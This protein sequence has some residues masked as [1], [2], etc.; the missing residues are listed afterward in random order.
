MYPMKHCLGKLTCYEVYLIPIFL[1]SYSGY[2]QVAEFGKSYINITK[3]ANGGT[4]ET[5]DVIE[6]RATFAVRSGSFDSCAYYDVI[7]AGTSYVA[8]TLRILTNE[9]KTYKQF[10]DA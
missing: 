9:E 4:F 5:N 1:I 6:I 7:P 2:S 8:N 3:G 10:T